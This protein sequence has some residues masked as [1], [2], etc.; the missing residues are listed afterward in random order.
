MYVWHAFKNQ[1][2]SRL[3]LGRCLTF[4]LTVYLA[5]SVASKKLA[6]EKWIHGMNQRAFEIVHCKPNQIAYP[7]NADHF[8]EV[9]VD[10]K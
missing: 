9:V 6:S 4:A 7:S 10:A 1:L 5:C 2:E 8:T 3:N